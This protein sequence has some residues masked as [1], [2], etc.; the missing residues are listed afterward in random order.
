MKRFAAIVAVA[1]LV[2][3]MSVGT[4]YAGVCVGM[5]CSE[6][7]WTCAE[8]GTP[9]CPDMGGDAPALHDACQHG[10]EREADE[11]VAVTPALEQALVADPLP[12]TEP[13]LPQGIAPASSAPDARGAPHLTAVIRI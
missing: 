8:A 13:E 3:T 10:P 7:T 4:A 1:T 2:L 5:D 11:A 9:A 12:L 6:M